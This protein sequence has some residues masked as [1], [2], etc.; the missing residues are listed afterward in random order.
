M[1]CP[2]AQT[3]QMQSYACSRENAMSSHRIWLVLMV[4]LGHVDIATI[5]QFDVRSYPLAS[6]AQSPESSHLEKQNKENEF[7][8]WN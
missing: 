1:I 8:K 3:I 6:S 2:T 7:Q 5:V 4:Y